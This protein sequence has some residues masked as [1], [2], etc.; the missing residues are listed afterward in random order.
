MIHRG[1][2]VQLLRPYKLVREESAPA[3]G[4]QLGGLVTNIHKEY[5]SARPFKE[6]CIY[7]YC[8]GF[9]VALG[10]ARVDA[11]SIFPN[12]TT[13]KQL[14]YCDKFMSICRYINDHCTENLT[15]DQISQIAGFSKYHFCRL[16]KK[17][18]ETSFYDYLMSKRIAYVETLLI[19]PDISITDAAML[20]GFN[21]IST[22][23]RVFKQ[24]KQCSPTQYR[25][26][27]WH[28]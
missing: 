28:S 7:A 1:G 27:L 11:G 9:F 20:A 10:R 3:L 13:S 6:S 18:T 23:N 12:S 22:F 2:L 16:F 4:A 21:S 26:F 17:F 15:V 19:D 25:A 24:H 5:F 14:E 8:I